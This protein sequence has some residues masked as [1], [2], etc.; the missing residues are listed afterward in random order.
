MPIGLVTAVDFGLPP[1]LVLI[2]AMAM[3]TSVFWLGFA[4]LRM[5]NIHQQ[6][7]DKYEN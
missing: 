5:N 2:G 6:I 3:T 7:K 4:L 1:A